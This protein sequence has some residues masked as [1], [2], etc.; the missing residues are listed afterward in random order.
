MKLSARRAGAG[1]SIT[2]IAR[3]P[4]FLGVLGEEGAKYKDK[5]TEKRKD[6]GTYQKTKRLVQKES[7]VS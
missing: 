6:T 5:E 2:V 7:W 1:L 3:E 4:P